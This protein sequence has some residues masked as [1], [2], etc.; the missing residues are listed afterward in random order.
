MKKSILFLLVS[1][2]FFACESERKAINQADETN[3]NV[4]SNESAYQAKLDKYVPVKLTTDISKLSA[5]EKEMI[6]IL[7]KA[8]KIMDELFWIESFGDKDAL[9]SSCLLYTSP[10][11]RDRTR[12]R[13]P[14]SA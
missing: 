10:S 8:A 5:K 12:S 14:S 13:M 1:I 6:P 11:P 7:I 4:S 9:L 3:T 2:L